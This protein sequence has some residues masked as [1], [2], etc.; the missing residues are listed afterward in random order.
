MASTNDTWCHLWSS[1]RG[2]KRSSESALTRVAAQRQISCFVAA[3]QLDVSSELVAGPVSRRRSCYRTEF[4]SF[5]R[6]FEYLSVERPTH[7]MG[8]HAERAKH[9]LRS[10]VSV[11]CKVPRSRKHRVRETKS[12]RRFGYSRWALWWRSACRWPYLHL[13]RRL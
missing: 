2:V 8:T 13:A 7:H 11:S 9:C 4:I 3:S 5:R 12:V 10:L 6:P 1:C